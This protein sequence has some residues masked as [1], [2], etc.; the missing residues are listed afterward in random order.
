MNGPSY[1]NDAKRDAHVGVCVYTKSSDSTAQ[2]AL[3]THT[4]PQQVHRKVHTEL[5]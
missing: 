1:Y 4:H 5:C 3:H 2:C